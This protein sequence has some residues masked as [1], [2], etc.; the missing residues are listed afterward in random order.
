[1][2]GI[3]RTPAGNWRAYWRG[4][5]GKQESKTFATKREAS[6]FIAQVT[7]SKST[8]N[9]VSPH[10]GR[11]LFETHAR[12]WI[13][14]WNTEATTTARD[15]S[16][17]EN[18]VIK[19][20]GSW[21]LA[22][23]DHLAIQT[24]VTDLGR[25]L[26]PA[27]VAECRR[28]TGGVLRS[29]V[30][31]R[32]IAFNPCEDIR[33]PSRRVRDTDEKVISREDLRGLL[34]PAVP[35]RYRAVVAMAAGA[36][37]R[38]GEV[39][40]VCL[41]AIDL[42]RAQVRVIRTVIE[43][44]GHTSFKPFPKSTA[45]RRTVPLPAWLVG[46]MREHMAG[47]SP[48]EGG[49]VFPNEVGG[50]LRRTLFRTRI[51]RPSLVRAGLL[52]NVT[53]KGKRRFTASWSDETGAH[54]MEFKTRAAAIKH[55]VRNQPGGL[56]FHDLRHSYATWLVDD[57]VPPNM[58]QRVMGHERSST[59]LDLYTRRTDDPTRILRALDDDEDG[60]DGGSDALVPA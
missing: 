30:R 31:N 52:G 8:G 21:P 60:D 49:L 44:S 34:L 3:R 48:G 38:W 43:V 47:V 27:T 33:V 14:S 39:V 29:A 46:I 26:S 57:G 55:V 42:E 45:G 12:R 41:D 23:I 19:Q 18:H 58:V 25:G 11:E 40:G 17:M 10:A 50:A 4:P 51:W 24:W 32:L 16:L 1:M 6:T 15:R 2:A 13:E 36:G 9:Y 7:T 22:K 56:R 53:E 37:L 20:W 5:S 28:L 59:T 35:E 54:Q